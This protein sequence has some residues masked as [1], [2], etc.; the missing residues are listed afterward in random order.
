MLDVEWYTAYENKQTRHL[1]DESFLF[2]LHS[3]VNV[4][5]IQRNIPLQKM[6]SEIR[7]NVFTSLN[8]QIQGLCEH[9]TGSGVVGK[10]SSELMIEKA[11]P[12]YL[13]YLHTVN[14]HKHTPSEYSHWFSLYS[15][16]ASGYVTSGM[17][18]GVCVCVYVWTCVLSL[19]SLLRDEWPPTT[20]TTDAH[21][22]AN[23]EFLYWLYFLRPC[24][25]LI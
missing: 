23:M 8:V 5:Q 11:L 2:C 13:I 20:L 16:T 12:R 14:K 21:P 4:I 9:T 7:H 17:S 22:A 25:L 24:S 1:L 15:T 18:S 6:C 10:C 3:S 19:R